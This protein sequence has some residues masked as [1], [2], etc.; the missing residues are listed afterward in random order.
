MGSVP[1]RHATHTSATP[2]TLVYSHSYPY[3]HDHTADTDHDPCRMDLNH[4][5]IHNEA[6][7]TSVKKVT[8]AVASMASRPAYPLFS[9]SSFPLNTQVTHIER[10]SHLAVR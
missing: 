5:R 3:L 1:I 8:E 9:R 6:I 10:F 2:K 4:T 7:C